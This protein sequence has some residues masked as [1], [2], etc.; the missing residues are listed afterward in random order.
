M[1]TK[2]VL[3]VIAGIVLMTL[4]GCETTSTNAAYV[5][6]R[7]PETLVAGNQI[8]ITDFYMASDDM[9]NSLVTSGVLDRA[10]QQPAIMAISR[11][12]ND[13][14]EQF[15][16]DQL[17]KKIRVALNQTGKVVT[18]TT[19]GLGGQ[20]EDELAAA[21][22][23]KKEFIEGTSAVPDNTP[24]FTL[25]GKILQPPIAREGNVRQNSYIFQLSLTETTTGLALWE[26]EKTI[27]KQFNRAAIS[28]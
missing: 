20:A 12:I 9:V 23:A 16:T 26:D 24:N 3:P 21:L 19:I 1:K 4:S 15:D 5:D 11:I 17:V 13:T 2:I 14:R 27:T 25:S 10:P 28:W 8:T 18:T 7:G 6:S 22:R